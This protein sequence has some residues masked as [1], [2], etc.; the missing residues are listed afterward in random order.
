MRSILSSLQRCPG[1]RFLEWFTLEF[2]FTSALQRKRK[3]FP[4]CTQN[5]PIYPSEDVCVNCGD[6]GGTLLVLCIRSHAL[7]WV[8]IP[9]GWASRETLAQ[10]SWESAVCIY[11]QGAAFH[12]HTLHPPRFPG[13]AGGGHLAG[14]CG[15]Q[16][17]LR[18]TVSNQEATLS[19]TSHLSLWSWGRSRGWHTGIGAVLLLLAWATN[20]Y[21]SFLAC[22]GG[23]MIYPRNGALGVRGCFPNSLIGHTLASFLFVDS[24]LC[25]PDSFSHCVF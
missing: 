9:F 2:S 21:S 7:G 23:S 5:L 6:G 15:A 3:L 13:L 8:L 22:L 11:T 4:S 20:M 16:P 10:Y 1:S 18:L 25:I 24:L 12:C 14:A 17:L 19:Q